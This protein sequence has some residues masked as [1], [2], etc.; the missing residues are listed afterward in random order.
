MTGKVTR[1]LA[2]IARGAEALPEL[3]SEREREVL[4]LIARG[5]TN[6]EIAARL[7]ISEATTKTHVSRVLAKLGLRS[8]MQAA[9][10][11]RTAGL[12]D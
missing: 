10:A 9:V 7:V 2:L 12:V 11:A 5:C 1:W 3:L 4:A 8:R 6:R